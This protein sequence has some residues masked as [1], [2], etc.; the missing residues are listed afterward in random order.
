MRVLDEEYLI[1]SLT[2]VRKDKCND[3]YL[4]LWGD[5]THAGLRPS[6]V[7]LKSIKK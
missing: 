4:L 1:A 6:P 5:D 2:N 3:E 7:I